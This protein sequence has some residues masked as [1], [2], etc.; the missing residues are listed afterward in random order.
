MKDLIKK[1]LLRFLEDIDIT[2]VQPEKLYI[3]LKKLYNDDGYKS[4]YTVRKKYLMELLTTDLSE[5]QR[6]QTLGRLKE[7][8][9]LS[10]NIKTA[11][12]REKEKKLKSL[13]IEE[14]GK[15]ADDV[16]G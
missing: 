8:K 11:Y 2:N 12:Q 1:Y 16:K 4:Y 6:E 9:A 3:F 7:L 5:Q 15:Q 14:L 10:A 13:K